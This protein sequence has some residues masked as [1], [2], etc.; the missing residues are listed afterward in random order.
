MY[1]VIGNTSKYNDPPALEAELF[2]NVQSLIAT[3]ISPDTQVS[4]GLCLMARLVPLSAVFDK[5]MEPVVLNAKEELGLR[6]HD[7]I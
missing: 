2:R 1:L 3:S 4:L 5:K 7:L 6:E